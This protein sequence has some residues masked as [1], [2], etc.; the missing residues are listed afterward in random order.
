[1]ILRIATKQWNRGQY[2]LKAMKTGGGV[3]ISYRHYSKVANWHD[4][5]RLQ[6][7]IALEN[8]KLC[9]PSRVHA[10]LTFVQP[11]VS[12]QEFNVLTFGFLFLLEKY[13]FHVKSEYGKFTFGYT[14]LLPTQHNAISCTIN[15]GAIPF[16]DAE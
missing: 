2:S 13:A 6:S 11:Y 8:W 7:A 9:Y 14:L 5:N 10:A 3:I 4:W 16:L 15:K 1:M 12:I